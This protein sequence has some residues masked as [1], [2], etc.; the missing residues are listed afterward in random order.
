MNTVGLEKLRREQAA[1][2]DLSSSEQ[3]CIAELWRGLVSGTCHVVDE[4][5][6]AE[7][8]YLVVRQSE[9]RGE[10]LS[11]RRLAILEQLLC[12]GYQLRVAIDFALAPSTVA[13]SA[14]GAL[15]ALGASGR[16][17]R[18]HP[19]LVLAATAAARG[20]SRLAKR[21]IIVEEAS[22]LQVWSIPRPELRCVSLSPAELA[23]SG[24]LVEGLSYGEIAEL[25]GTSKRTIANQIAAVFRRLRVSGRNELLH[26]WLTDDDSCPVPP[27][28]PPPASAA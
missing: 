27:S 9:Q 16:P 4:F 2:S 25:R 6:S 12:G 23:V 24:R 28:E 1:A 10:P 8:C 5:F 22:T 11:G 19:L 14:R 21:S 17:S 7:R 13:A 3:G 20:T 26:L 15:E 18:V